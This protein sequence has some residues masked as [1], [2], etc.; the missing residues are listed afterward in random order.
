MTKKLVMF[1]G[2]DCCGKSTQI[3]MLSKYL[4]LKHK[5][6]KVV[7]NP[8]DPGWTRTSIH[9]L[10]GDHGENDNVVTSGLKNIAIGNIFLVDKI[11]AIL[12]DGY[13]NTLLQTDDPTEYIIMDRF[14]TSLVYNF[15]VDE[16]KSLVEEFKEFLKEN[17][18]V[19]LIVI[20]LKIYPENA[21]KRLMLRTGELPDRFENMPNIREV[22]HRYGEMWLSHPNRCTM[23]NLK[24]DLDFS[25]IW[26]TIDG[27]PEKEFIHSCIASFFDVLMKKEDMEK[28]EKLQRAHI[29]QIIPI[30]S[31]R[32][33]NQQPS[34]FLK[35]EAPELV[36][37]NV[38]R[39]HPEN[40]SL[41]DVPLHGQIFF[42]DR[43]FVLIPY[44]SDTEKEIVIAT[45]SAITG[46]YATIEH[47]LNLYSTLSSL[48]VQIYQRVP[49]E[50]EVMLYNSKQNLDHDTALKIKSLLLEDLEIS[51]GDTI[52]EIQNIESNYSI[53]G[54]FQENVDLNN[55]D[56]RSISFTIKKDEN[57][58]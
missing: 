4:D 30:T 33:F 47:A 42:L 29:V 49:Y 35:H 26:I 53:H 19:D 12:P 52:C 36:K 57:A 11:L 5:T 1:E 24:D 54:I 20:E 46:D 32:A 10:L 15:G 6:Y 43:Y 2:I 37:I 22:F 56:L 40:F 41:R 38:D 50:F 17:F 23:I 51:I 3:E 8:I 55:E 27:C 28:P 58:D 48:D 45:H 39:Y 16:V 34:T 21:I 9:K 44:D 14:Y 31:S 25:D 7:I 13:L 18:D